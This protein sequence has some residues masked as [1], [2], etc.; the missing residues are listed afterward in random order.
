MKLA[1]VPVLVLVMI[2]LP[3]A[4]AC[5]EAVDC[6]NCLQ[7]GAAP[8][9]AS[10]AA[11]DDRAAVDD[12]AQD[13]SVPPARSIPAESFADCAAFS[14]AIRARAV[15]AM[16]RFVDE[17]ERSPNN[18]CS[19]DFGGA[20]R[21]TLPDSNV[22]FSAADLPA[23][24]STFTD[25]NTQVHGI[26]EGDIVETDGRHLYVASQGLLRVLS[27]WPAANTHELAKVRFAGIVK[28]LLLH[29]QRL[30]VLYTTRQVGPPLRFR[31]R[32][33]CP[34]CGIEA[35]DGPSWIAVLDV[36][37]PAQPELIRELELSGSVS[38]LRR[39][40]STV[41]AVISDAPI[42]VHTT[43]VR[44]P[45][46]VQTD[47]E[48][49]QRM[50]GLRTYRQESEA[51]IRNADILAL[52]PRVHDSAFPDRPTTCNNI[53]L[54]EAG[55]T[56][57]FTT[58]LS[59]DLTGVR[60]T[61]DVKLLERSGM[62]YVSAESA[63]VAVPEQAQ[64][65]APILAGAPSHSVIH[66]VAVGADPAASRYEASGRVPGRLLNQFAMDEWQGHLRVASTVEAVGSAER[67][68]NAVSVLAQQ[69]GE[70]RTVGLLD[71]IAPREDVRSVRFMGARGYVVTFEVI[72]PLFVLALEEP[73][74]P[75][76]LSELKVEGFSTYIHPLD[77]GHLLTIGYET[78][79]RQFF[80][81]LNAIQL[82]LFDVRD[83]FAPR[84]AHKK[85]IGTRATSSD[86][87]Q[88]HLAFT[89]Y[90]EK[91]VLALPMSICEGG[92]PSG[93][94]SET[95][96]SGLMLF[97]VDVDSGLKERGRI[98][99]PPQQ[100]Q[101]FG[102]PPMRPTS[103]SSPSCL[104]SW[105]FNASSVQ[106]GVMIDDFVYAISQDQVK[107]RSLQAL[108]ADVANVPLPVESC[109]LLS[110]VTPHGAALPRTTDSGGLAR[111]STCV[112]F[113]FDGS[114]ECT[115]TLTR[116]PCQR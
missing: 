65:Q 85:V 112:C 12:A 19:V 38:A 105:R 98:P 35:Q 91:K 39:I 18:R 107:V 111:L 60:P 14:A 29:E 96:F 36:R 101:P 6:T 17:A 45:G 40:G 42:A 8:V 37:N 70:L 81:P 74:A 109:T 54:V 25:T 86:A 73:R 44:I 20:L 30:V 13:G 58:L 93:A 67:R 79:S 32:G 52:L 114:Y 94:G 2:V 63:Y 103:A 62:V 24:P 61:T 7:D 1:L 89:Y 59:F 10:D 69:N 66:R 53:H 97:D 28:Q 48:R 26:D 47:L 77:D 102:P 56:L 22:S 57:T 72:D 23:N 106:R 33:G 83:P 15:A 80:G 110:T 34:W 46:C 31:T 99:F 68:Y 4:G 21:G 95:T 64:V 55:D 116:A 88:N 78:E 11:V 92:E 49:A 51:A 100:V 27:A 9:G 75:R 90:P 104:P 84:L 76:V 50:A 108:E 87:N 82:Q 43:S 71:R 16:H 41:H 3:F 5:S 115:D 113:C